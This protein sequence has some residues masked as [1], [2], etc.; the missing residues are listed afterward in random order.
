LLLKVV[1]TFGAATA[2]G[3]LA[4]TRPGVDASG[5][6]PVGDADAIGGLPRTT[7]GGP[8][9]APPSAGALPDL[10]AIPGGAA[11][12][13]S[14][15]SESIEH[16]EYKFTVAESGLQAPNRAHNF[17]SRYR[18]TGVEI[19]PRAQSAEEA[20]PWRLSWRTKAWGRSGEMTMLGAVSPQVNAEGT[21]VTYPHGGM[22]EWYENRK[23]GLEQGFTV[24]ERPAGEGP[25][26]IEGEFGGAARPVLQDGAIDLRD[27][28]D[29]TLVRYG[30]LA[31]R[32]AAGE[33]VPASLAV[34]GSTVA[35]LV[36]DKGAVYPLIVDPLMSTPAWTAESNQ[37][38]AEFGYSVSTA[39]DVNGDGYSDAIVGAQ[40][41]DNG[42]ANE[43]RAFSYLGSNAGLS[44]SAAWTA[45]SNQA[46]A[47]FGYSVSTA[48]DVNGDGYS[49][50]IIGADLFD[51]GEED[52]GRAFVYQGSASGLTTTAVRLESNQAM[53]NFGNSVSTAGDVNG[54]G[55]SDV[56]IGAWLYDNGQLNEGRVF[57]YHGSASGIA[58]TPA[59]STEPNHI[60]GAL[61]F[62][63]S[64]AGD[65]NGD[66]YSDIIVGAPYYDNGPGEG[67]AFAYHGSAAGLSASPAWTAESIEM[68]AFFG[69]SV[70]TA[71]DVNGD[72]YSDII[73]GVPEF[74]IL[75][76]EGKAHVYNGSASGLSST[77]AWTAESDYPN[78]AFGRSVASAGD[79]NGDGYGD[80]IVG[81][82]AYRLGGSGGR[83]FVYQGSALGLPD[84]PT[85]TA[86]SMHD[87]F[88]YFG[89]AVATA[90][91]VNG[92]GFSDVIIGAIWY[93]NGQTD[94]GRAFVYHGSAAG[95]STSA[96]WTAES[97]QTSANFGYS[98]S[99][100][101]DVNG[102]G[103]SDVLVGA[104]RYDN[105]QADEGR[106]FVYHG[107]PSGPSTA[108]SWTAESNQ[109]SSRYGESVATAGDVNNDGYSDVIVGAPG[110]DNGQSGEGRAYVYHGSASG[111]GTTAART[112]ES[113]LASAELGI[114]VSTAGDVNGDGFSDV[115][116][117]A[118]L[119]ANGQSNEGRAFA[120]HGSGTGIGSTAAWTRESNQ[121]SAWFGYSV[122]TAGDVNG[123]GFSDVIV[124]API[125]DNGQTN[126]GR[127]YAYHGSASGLATTAAWTGETNV[128]SSQLGWSV[129]TA[130]DVNG[131]GF[132]D[133][134][135]SALGEGKVLIYRGSATGLP[136]SVTWQSIGSS[137]A[138]FGWSVSTA[139]D[140]NGDGFS[141]VIIG[142]RR[143]DNGQTDEG[144]AFV[145]HGSA[146]WPGIV[147]DWTGE[148]NQAGA[149][150]GYSVST[151][152]DVNGDGYSDVI[153]GAHL[154][155]NG[156]VDEGRAF[157]YYGNKARPIRPRSLRTVGGSPIA[158]L[159]RSDS[160][161]AFR[162]AATGSSPGGRAR[163]RLE[164]EVKPL[165][166][167]F[168]GTGITRG[169]ITNTGLPG[170]SGST[171]EL[172]EL[173]SGLSPDTPYHWR[174]RVASDSPFFPWSRWVSAVGNGRQETD[175]RTNT[176]GLRVSE[177][178]VAAAPAQPRLLASVNPNPFGTT[179]ELGYHVPE[180]GRLHLRVY[181]VT[182]REVAVL[183]DEV[184]NA[185]AY[186]VRW[187]GRD[188]E[189]QA[190][191]AGVYFAQLE[192]GDRIES[193]KLV[194]TR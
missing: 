12:W 46:G 145:Y 76:G 123:D 125:Y 169:A 138:F 93:D 26:R 156:S 160:P 90:G 177:G 24:T 150:F 11:D 4:T 120:Y 19:E 121:A 60:G 88:D 45:E 186:R 176:G 23:E 57:T 71:G 38:G 106:A 146:A 158:L 159:G 36:Q 64:T 43:G 49:D 20:V 115:I 170:T 28:N 122:S 34:A 140:V 133:V 191:P 6:E 184:Q 173:A 180:V 189:G 119:F 172:N 2:I 148:S 1:V 182:G 101:D 67:W 22:S 179:T 73:V 141:D 9:P 97:N 163:V 91:D 52:E 17:R 25:L 86:N 94:E 111:L 41:Y 181:S 147:P 168:D 68:G 37:F 102:D 134:I 92:D 187:E 165:G 32:D 116:V 50:V 131:D 109:A 128:A 54:D 72:G 142:A 84:T 190:L 157:I 151:A 144:R 126:E 110:Y 40:F 66:G 152:G 87:V 13:W 132:S 108:A 51:N 103:Y 61:G 53:A 174:L 161:S 21:R 149:E 55:Y 27:E 78:S 124:G 114:S 56:V 143:H 79:V 63:V 175:L 77:A 74:N 29:V 105:G 8:P 112:V 70:S 104:Y 62:C 15:V 127:T 130:G 75:G 118:W 171:V 47:D 31:V 167:L 129:S 30:E 188:R 44:T 185:G 153:V 5:S 65:V 3:M 107:S 95:L 113:N 39:G 69:W 137:S 85:W 42:E 117:G 192:L 162:L 7:S 98:V 100:A 183:V 10:S 89:F 18:E 99:T 58:V 59:W 81:A 96:G 194:L 166:V 178:D 80:V 193:Q 135:V 35:I 33:D 82:F 83:T 136:T 14:M 139:G 154:Y 16:E 164:Y 155:D 48:G